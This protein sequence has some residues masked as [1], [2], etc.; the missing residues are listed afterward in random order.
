MKKLFRFGIASL[1]LAM[2]FGAGAL[3]LKNMKMPQKVDASGEAWVGLDGTGIVGTYFNTANEALHAQASSMTSRGIKLLRD[4]T[5]SGN[6]WLNTTNVIVDLNGH[7]LTI[8]SS[9]SPVNRFIGIRDYTA[10]GN[11]ETDVT[12]TIKSST[13][14]GKING[15]CADSVLYIDPSNASGTTQNSHT[16]TVIIDSGVQ[17]KNFASGRAIML[18]KSA[19]LTV[20][21]GASVIEAHENGAWPGVI[22][23]GGSITNYGTIQGINNGVVLYPQEVG[24][25]LTNPS[26]SLSGASA[27]V[28]PRIL[29]KRAGGAG[30]TLSNY[31]YSEDNSS[32]NPV[33]VVFDSNVTISDNYNIFSNIHWK[34]KNTFNNYI[35]VSAN[36]SN[37]HTLTWAQQKYNETGY[38]QWKRNTYTVS[39]NING[40]KSGTTYSQSASAES[41][42]TLRNNNFTAQNYYSFKEWNTQPDGNGVSYQPGTSYQLNG[43]ITFYAIWYQT[44]TNKYDE[45]RLEYL[46]MESYTSE[47]GYCSDATHHYYDDAKDY[48]FNNMT[49]NQRTFFANNYA[50]EMARFQAWAIANEEG[51]VY[52][53]G[54]YVVIQNAKVTSIAE[55][56]NFGMI[57]IIAVCTSSLLCLG[58]FILRKKHSK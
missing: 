15:Y 14:G 32:V 16:A 51:I 37:H 18:H 24:G 40:G 56:N 1:A 26:I 25:V 33:N 47:L 17:V 4:T 31:S 44:D 28:T 58:L 39:Y 2:S 50:D 29:S 6:I 13:A 55:E 45:F 53:S 5:E 21:E 54:D 57:S 42:V 36:G 52:Q 43:N 9:G 11:I 12:L 49:K 27:L 41:S 30:V 7:T 10:Q 38:L 20:R 23:Y 34:Y 8:G 19:S 22:N 3:A 35:S 46:K 48:F